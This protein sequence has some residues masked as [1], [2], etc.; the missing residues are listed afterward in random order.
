MP[1]CLFSQLASNPQPCQL[2]WGLRETEAE[3]GRMRNESRAKWAD[4]TWLQ[5]QG[6]PGWE[7]EDFLTLLH[8]AKNNWQVGVRVLRERK[9]TVSLEILV[10]EQS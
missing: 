6:F 9:L 4:L 2:G 3:M 5:G 10:S 1:V 7:S 8:S